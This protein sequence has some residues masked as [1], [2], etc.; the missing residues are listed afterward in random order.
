MFWLKMK[1]RNL[2]MLLLP[3]LL[4]ASC[5]HRGGVPNPAPGVYYWKTTFELT[6]PQ[7]QWLR[8]QHIQ[9]LYLRLF[10]IVP[11]PQGPIPNATITFADTIP[12]SL[13]VIPTIFIDFTLFRSPVDVRVMAANTLQRISKMARTHGFHYTEVQF[14]CDWTPSTQQQYFDFLQAAHQID[15]SLILSSTIRLHQLSLP[16][17]PCTYG[18]LML[19]NTGNFRQPHLQHNP[20]LDAEDVKPYL[21]HLSTYRLPLCA[22]YPNFD[23]K[24]LFHHNQFR[25][26]LYN[27]NLS[28]PHSY[29][30]INA[31]TYRVIAPHDVPVAKGSPYIHLAPGDVVRHWQSDPAQIRQVQKMLSTHSRTIHQQTVIYHLS[32]IDSL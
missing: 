29:L 6:P 22:A 8:H 15:T 4:L 24:I 2:I 17:P 23:W 21:Q 9:K 12:A 11:S 27:E 28:D 3:L 16:A 1:F 30:P 5:R 18:V 25:G 14:D 32:A 13:T 26:I 19:Y 10:D 20:I 31:T 7:R